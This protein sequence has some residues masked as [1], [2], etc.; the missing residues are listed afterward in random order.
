MRRAWLATLT[1][2]IA[3]AVPAVS[4]AQ[5]PRQDSVSLSGTATAGSFM[6]TTLNATSGPSGESPSGEVRFSAFGVIQQG[7]PVTCLAVNGSAATLRFVDE[8]FFIGSA[9]TVVVTDGPDSFDVLFPVGGDPTDCST[10]GTP[11][12]VSGPLTTGDIVVVDAPPLPTT[13]DQCK[14]GGWQTFG[15]FKNQGDCVSFV[16]TGGKNPP[17]KKGG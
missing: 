1:T 3:C 4:F 15:V 6:I 14:D 5:V 7:G 13:K 9:M 16:A 10:P 12:G 2:A 11:S 8:L 17:G